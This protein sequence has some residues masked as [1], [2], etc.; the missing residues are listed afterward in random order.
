MKELLS[1]LAQPIA[2]QWRVQSRNK[3]KTKAICTAYIDA[4]DVMNILDANCVWQSEFKEVSGF[5]FAGIGIYYEPS[6]EWAWRWDCGQRVEDNPSDNMYDQ[7][8]KSAASDA[9]KRAAVQWGIGRFLYDLPTVTLP[10]DQWN[11]YD[12]NNNKVYDLTK[13]INNKK[14]NSS[15]PLDVP[16]PQPK[17]DSELPELTPDKMDAMIKYISEGKIKEVETAIKKYKLNKAQS[18]TISAMISQH[19]T[20]AVKAAAKK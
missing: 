8:G 19:K 15:E 6:G 13:Y 4:R 18:A 1:K 16:K 20:N 17:F 12:E 7:A 14:I 9:F 5:I 10:C 11:V 3:D 2:Y